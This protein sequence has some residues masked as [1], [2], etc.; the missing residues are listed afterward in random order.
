MFLI[1]DTETTGFP[2]KGLSRNDPRQ[3]R[4]CQ[5]AFVL[6]DKNFRCL[7]QFS[8]FIK[9]DGWTISAG[10]SQATGIT[11]EMCREKGKPMA[12]IIPILEHA[13]TYNATKV[14]AHN[15]ALDS[16]LVDIESQQYTYDWNHPR[17][18]CTMQ[19]MTPICKLPSKRMT[20]KWPKLIEAYEYLFGEKF[21]GAH[22]ALADVIAT[23]R[24]FR[25]LVENRHVT[26]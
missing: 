22:D 12:Q 11:D 17:M 26:V 4:I 13:I 24:V 7:E 15:I 14:V 10:A 21:D 5:L 19:L 9:P 16:R 6:L 25:W 1:F 18:V 3:A 23:A 2:S 8:S 20:H